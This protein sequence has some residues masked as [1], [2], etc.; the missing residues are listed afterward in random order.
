M[1]VTPSPLGSDRS[2][3]GAADGIAVGAA[4][5]TT[6]TT[7]ATIS[8]APTAATRGKDDKNELKKGVALSAGS[9]GETEARSSLNEL[10]IGVTV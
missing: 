1:C 7:T 4:E 3:R 2:S 10:N 5:M 9:N 8:V 6:T